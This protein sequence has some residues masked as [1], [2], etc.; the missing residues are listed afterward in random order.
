MV[1]VAIRFNVDGDEMSTCRVMSVF[2]KSV[3]QSVEESMKLCLR[4]HCKYKLASHI[5]QHRLPDIYSSSV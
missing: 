3:H 4:G 5:L 1:N 2:K